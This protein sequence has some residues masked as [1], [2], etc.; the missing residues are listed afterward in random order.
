MNMKHLLVV[1]AF[2]FTFTLSDQNNA[3]LPVTGVKNQGK[4]I[5][6]NV[7]CKYVII[8]SVEILLTINWGVL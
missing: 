6:K 7:D 5:Q 3:T 2:L 1:L 8:P 4:E